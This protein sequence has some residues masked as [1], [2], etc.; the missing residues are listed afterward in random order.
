MRN[1]RP[2]FA[3]L[4]AL[5]LLGG[6]LL[7]ACGG[8]SDTVVIDVRTAAE[9]DEAHLRGA[10]NLDLLSGE[11]ARALPGLDPD[12]EF[13]IYCRTGLRSFDAAML[14]EAAGFTD[15]TDAGSLVEAAELTGLPV[16]G[17]HQ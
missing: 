3:V 2:W 1:R 8:G 5:A 13:V 17:A 16:V 15:V 11:F 6:L 4:S 10:I 14:M 7:G 12:G 9:F